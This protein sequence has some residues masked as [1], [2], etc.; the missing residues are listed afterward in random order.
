[1]NTNI[2]HQ[3][4]D[5]KVTNIWNNSHKC[6]IKLYR[7]Q[8]LNTLPIKTQVYGTMSWYD[9]VANSSSGNGHQHYI[10]TTSTHTTN[11][12]INNNYN[13]NNNTTIYK[14]PQPVKSHYKGVLQI[15]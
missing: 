4:I 15:N 11:V 12:T 13:N 1:M 5:Y 3:T 10:Q 8:M 2:N 7:F 14:A 9:M 6:R